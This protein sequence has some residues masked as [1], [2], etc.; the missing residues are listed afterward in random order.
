MN[1]RFCSNYFHVKYGGSLQE[2]ELE[3]QRRRRREERMLQLKREQEA[4]AAQLRAKAE[5]AARSEITAKHEFDQSAST[6]SLSRTEKLEDAARTSLEKLE[7]R[8]QSK[9]TTP[10]QQ[11]PQ[12]IL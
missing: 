10:A 1:K 3:A 2:E 9:T 7:S 5:E 6:C 4:M 8:L 11:K 12:V